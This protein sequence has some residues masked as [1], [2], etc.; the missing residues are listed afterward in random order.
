MNKHQEQ[1]DIFVEQP[2]RAEKSTPVVLVL[3]DEAFIGIELEAALAEG[4]FDVTLVHSCT[5]AAAWLAAHR[6]AAAILDVKLRDGDCVGIA[7]TL[8]ASGIPF[9]L[10]TGDKLEG[11]H[12]ALQQ[13]HVIY[14]PADA[15]D[16]VESVRSMVASL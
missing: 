1:H 14:K 9:V 3:E 5:D 6:P 7:E 16:I 11:D 15:R 4:G 10:Y 2:E 8:T 12:E 13:Q